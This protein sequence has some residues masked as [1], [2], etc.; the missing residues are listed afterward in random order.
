MRVRVSE[1]ESVCVCVCER[2]SV[3]EHVCVREKERVFARVRVCVREPYTPHPIPPG[4]TGPVH[5]ERGHPLPLARVS[6]RVSVCMC[7]RVRE[8]E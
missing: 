8:R 2:E 6:E 1:R 7:E 3:C 4:H 5:P